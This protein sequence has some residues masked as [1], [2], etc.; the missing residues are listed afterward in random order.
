MG[1]ALGC[2][3]SDPTTVEDPLPK[4]EENLE[5]AKVKIKQYNKL[6]ATQI[7]KARS[8]APTNHQAALL[9][10]KKKK[11]LQG[12]LLK[13]QRIEET[14]QANILAIQEAKTTETMY[15]NMKEA[16]V[17]LKHLT[18]VIKLSD[19]HALT[20]DLDEIVVNADEF[21]RVLGEE[22][23]SSETVDDQELEAELAALLEGDGA[24]LPGLGPAVPIT[25][26]RPGT[27]PVLNARI[28]EAKEMDRLLHDLEYA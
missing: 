1:L 22:A 18:G 14:L 10:L 5:I 19:V 20:D 16:S 12:Q 13:Y 27:D 23:A 2:R 4:L 3:T 24:L 17:G 6:I 28:R 8:L 15:N 21:Q 26:P 7:Q 9:A 11:Q 25:E